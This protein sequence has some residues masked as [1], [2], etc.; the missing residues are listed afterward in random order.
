MCQ[1]VHDHVTHSYLLHMMLRDAT[2]PAET[3]EEAA[4]HLNVNIKTL[5]MI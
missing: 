2:A 1:T 4:M 3:V 5:E